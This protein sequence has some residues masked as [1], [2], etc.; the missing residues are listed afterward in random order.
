MVDIEVE[1]VDHEDTVDTSL[2]G[3]EHFLEGDACNCLV[4]HVVG[5]DEDT[6]AGAVYLVPEEVPELVLVFVQSYF[7]SHL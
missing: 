5:G 7:L 3:V 4:V 2:L 1:V 6:V